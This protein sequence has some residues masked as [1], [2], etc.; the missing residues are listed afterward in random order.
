LAGN[1]TTTSQTLPNGIAQPAKGLYAI[2]NIA[3]SGQWKVKMGNS[4]IHGTTVLGG[5]PGRET[6][7]ATIK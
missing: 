6:V 5:Q 4:T 2:E 1:W 7:F 3:E